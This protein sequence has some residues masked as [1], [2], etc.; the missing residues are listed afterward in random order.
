MDINNIFDNWKSGGNNYI[1]KADSPNRWVGFE[2]S[3]IDKLKKDFSN[4]FYLI[5]WGTRSDSDYYCIPYH[6][7]EHLF[8]DDNMT[9]G[10]NTEKGSARWTTTIQ[11]HIFKMHSNIKYSVNIGEFYGVN[12]S[13]R[14]NIAEVNI[15][16]YTGNNHLLIKILEEELKYL[17]SISSDK[18]ALSFKNMKEIRI[19]FAGLIVFTFSKDDIWM[20]VSPET[21]PKIDKNIW[22]WE[23]VEY[24]EYVLYKN[25]NIKNGYL[26]SFEQS[27][28]NNIKNNHFDVIN[29]IAKNN[30]ALDPRTE[31]NHKND[32][33]FLLNK[34][35]NLKLPY[36]GYSLQQEYSDIIDRNEEIK[37][38]YD[39]LDKLDK[40]EKQ[41]VIATRIGQNR[42][43]KE[44]L[45]KY[46]NKCV[47]CSLEN[48]HLLRAS[49]IKPWSESND[50]ER[51][52]VANGLLLC[53]NHDSL[54]DSGLISFSDSGTI[55]I[56]PALSGNDEE[57]LKLKN[58][59][60][61]IM[62]ESLEYFAWHR[63]SVFKKLPD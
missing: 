48:N 3:I 30:Y 62:E 58:I 53:S 57:I 41:S 6:I 39:Y 17:N 16:K 15:N 63:E 11:N 42:F 60:I 37:Q 7:V 2:K 18:W 34:K 12:I 25:I 22:K 14:S 55:L 35:Y 29:K 51:L 61:E 33:L 56:S 50:H 38:V 47:M 59:K 10:K 28:W 1:L 21:F 4:N 52:D 19:H 5:I 44:L 8:T 31:N 27:Y 23:E 43:R 24:K 13:Q 54:F 32:F 40:T 46:D 36:P 20:S 26:K 9:K 45:L 49:H